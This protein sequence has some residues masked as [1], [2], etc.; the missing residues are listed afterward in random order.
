MKRA[1]MLFVLLLAAGGLLTGCVTF[2]FAPT[3]TL[4]CDPALVGKWHSDQD[5]SARKGAATFDD[6][7]VLTGTND[8]GTTETYRLR[9]TEYDGV[10]YLVMRED[11]PATVSDLDGKTIETWPD[12]RVH[13]LRYRLEGDRLEMWTAD[14]RVAESLD[15]R[16]VR[17][18]SDRMRD[19]KTGKPIESVV[20]GNIYLS[21]K[22]KRL[23]ALLRE[24]G[25]ELYS[26]MAADKALVLHRAPEGASP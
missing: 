8:D 22:R 10:R 14:A 21:G 7:C 24:R 3:E 26:G 11:A 23:A 9:T 1:T 25:D 20:P 6:Q 17:A 5:P 12:T 4:G 13:L 18:H 15:V 16:G 19:P 2:E